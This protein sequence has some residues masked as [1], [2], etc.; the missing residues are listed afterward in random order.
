MEQACQVRKLGFGRVLLRDQR[1]YPRRLPRHLGADAAAIN[2]L[3]KRIR[4][5][6]CSILSGLPEGFEANTRIGG[7]EIYAYEL[8]EGGYGAVFQGT[9]Q[10][11]TGEITARN[12]NKGDFE[13]VLYKFFNE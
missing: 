9:E 7:R 13:D 11:L 2:R 6:L 10:E 4:C 8:E 5:V 1:V 3:G 12:V